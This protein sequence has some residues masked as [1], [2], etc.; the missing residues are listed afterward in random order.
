MSS[1]SRG[2]ACGSAGDPSRA[3]FARSAGADPPPSRESAVA[4]PTS[5]GSKVSQLRELDLHLA[6]RVARA[7]RRMSR[8]SCVRIDDL[9]PDFSSICR[10]CAGRQLVVEDHDVDVGLPRPTRRRLDLAAPR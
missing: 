1:R 3:S 8:M 4:A 6:S 7:A 10:S 2:C 5:R 9:A